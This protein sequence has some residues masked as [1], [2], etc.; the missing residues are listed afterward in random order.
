MTIGLLTLVSVGK[1]NIYLSTE[2][3][4]TYFKIAYKRYSN[5]SIETI[6]Q[7]FKTLPD[8]SRRVTV[9]ISKN[10]DLLGQC[11]LYV[12]L[13]DIITSNSSSLP[14][15]IK[16]F[17]WAKKIGLVLLRY[18]DFEISG[19]LIERNFGDWLNIWN[20]LTVTI[21]KKKSYNKMIG[22]I[23]LLTKYTN[24][25]KSYGLNIPLNFW[26]CQ[27]TGLALPLIAMIHNDIKFHVEFNDFNVC[28]KESPTN[29]MQIQETFCLYKPNEI[30][31]QIVNGNVAIGEFIYFNEVNQYLYY[32]KISGNFVIPTLLTQSYLLIGSETLF[33][34]NIAV[35][36]LIIKD[37]SYFRF[38]TPS[39]IDAN[40]LVNY[41]Y[42]DNEER[43]NFIVKPHQY[44]VPQ[45][46]NITQQTVYSVNVAYKIPFINPNKIIFWRCN[47]VSN[48]MINDH[49][50]YSLAPL[51]S[52]QDNIV[53]QTQI[54]LNSIQ[55]VELTNQES[56]SILQTYINNFSSSQV[57]IYMYSFSLNPLEFQPSG[58]CNFSQ[59]DDTY[60]Q[61]TLNKRINYQNPAYINAYSIQYNVFKVEHGLG[62]IGFVL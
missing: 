51:T 50:N 55:R 53:E 14:N 42:L 27:D 11:Y 40:I 20:E 58:T 13:P 36:S 23:E 37:E 17:A 34:C 46:Q 26:F 21:A 10:A 25:K 39:I 54:I 18:I 12:V 33:E 31:K 8:F 15:G 1:E 32:N 60:L 29:Y 24:G 4:I 43:F 45:V 19:I 48:D 38:N 22:D 30:F 52:A 59:I 47:L 35:N 49:F 56:Y 57:G 6:A 41:I 62:S 9:N 61:L 3:E 7:Y 16:K 44:L 28:Y 5:F 2:P